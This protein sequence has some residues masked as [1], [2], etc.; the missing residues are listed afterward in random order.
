MNLLTIRLSILIALI[1]ALSIT[2]QAQEGQHWYYNITE[3]NIAIEGYDVVAYH[4][5]DSAMKGMAQWELEHEG[6][7]YLFASQQNLN[8][9]RS[10]PAKY[11]PAFGGWCT[12]FMGIDVEQT[13]FPPTRMESDPTNFLIKDGQLYLFRKTPRQD[14]KEVFTST[15]QQAILSTA[16]SFWQS[17]LELMK[18]LNKK[19]QG[20]NAMA[21]M[22]N[23]EW[24]PF[25]GK[26]EV[27][28]KWWADTT[29]TNVVPSKG[30]WEFR[31]GY[32]G[33]C[34]QDDFQSVPAQPFAGAPNGPAIRGYD[35]VK[36][37][38][39]MTYIPVNQGR[40]ATWLMTGKFT[41]PG[42]L[43]GQLETQDPY[44]NDILQK[45]EFKLVSKDYF[46]WRAHWSWDD[47]K[48]WKE[49]VGSAE[50]KRIE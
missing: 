6:V 4:A 40:A 30:E 3:D 31:Y 8:T 46:Q 50:C 14:F 49:N 23:L 29:G 35:V 47:G 45:I 42:Q 28:L 39:H 9:F 48:T 12:F 36:E 13:N 11:L 21:R 27:D 38:W 34:I 2:G 25:M 18:G 1:L 19:P 15:D 16:E 7:R 24:Q 10:D 5:Q 43:T 22:E 20:L 17:R 26:W 37:E 44:G 32:Y 41:G 33:F